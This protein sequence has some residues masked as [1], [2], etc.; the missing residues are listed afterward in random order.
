M[1]KKLQERWIS[2]LNQKRA[3]SSKFCKILHHKQFDEMI[4]TTDESNEVN[5]VKSIDDIV[6]ENKQ[7]IE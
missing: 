5:E 1:S 3:R 7:M 2:R 4:G 6:F